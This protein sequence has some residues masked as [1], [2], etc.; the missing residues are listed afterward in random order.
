[1][2]S[3]LSLASFQPG[4]HRRREAWPKMAHG[5]ALG[6]TAGRIR[7]R[8]AYIKG[9]PERREWLDRR[10]FD[11]V[12]VPGRKRPAPRQPLSSQTNRVVSERV[13]SPQT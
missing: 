7:N 5:L 2:M 1:M 12:G 10:G 8:E 11:W 13:G 6:E 3:P 4:M 9:N